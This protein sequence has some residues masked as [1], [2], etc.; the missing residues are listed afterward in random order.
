MHLEIQKCVT[1][2][3][4]SQFWLNLNQTTFGS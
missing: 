2:P 4:Q 1:Q 3:K